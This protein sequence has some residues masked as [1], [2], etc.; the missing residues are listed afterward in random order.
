MTRQGQVEW[1]HGS[2]ERLHSIR[3]GSTITRERGLAR[4][5]SHKPSI[6]SQDHDGSGGL[7]LRH[8]GRMPGFLYRIAEQVGAQDVDPHPTTTLSPGQEWLTRRELRVE[9]LEATA[10]VEEELL[11]EVEVRDLLA[12]ARKEVDAP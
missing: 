6:V 7:I 5:F 8:T 11:S 12:R 9:L 3:V 1:F 4:V 2:P 10:V